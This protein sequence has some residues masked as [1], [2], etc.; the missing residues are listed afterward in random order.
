[1]PWWDDDSAYGIGSLAVL[2]RPDLRPIAR[3]LR[4]T[5]TQRA[6]ADAYGKLVS[7]SPVPSG[8]S[9]NRRVQQLLASLYARETSDSAAQSL[10]QALL[11]AF[12]SLDEGIAREPHANW[13]HVLGCRMAV[14]MLK[15]RYTS[16]CGATVWRTDLEQTTQRP[17]SCCWT[18]ARSSGSC[19]ALAQRFY[20]LLITLG[21]HRP[22]Q[23][24]RLFRNVHDLTQRLPG[25]RPAGPAGRGFL[26]R[27]PAVGNQ[28]DR[29][30]MRCRTPSA[31][32]T[33]HGHR[34]C[35]FYRRATDGRLRSYLA[36]LFFD[37]LGARPDTDR[38]GNDRTV[39]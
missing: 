36:V 35:D 12:S 15:H 4:L 24:S 8:R 30:G 10:D 28:W 3:R 9:C 29:Y 21:R 19:G 17:G 37:R 13:R 5:A 26:G 38:R 27:L 16:A 18:A 25:Q 11:P 2:T 6:R 39:A 7:T 32:P 23:G 31:P 22:G 34:S 1:M 20:Q 33:R 14:A